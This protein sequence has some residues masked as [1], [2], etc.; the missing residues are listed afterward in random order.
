[1]ALKS[2]V[3]DTAN[4]LQLSPIQ[5]DARQNHL[6][7]QQ[8]LLDKAEWQLIEIAPLFK[9]LSYNSTKKWTRKYSTLS[10]WLLCHMKGLLPALDQPSKEWLHNPNQLEETPLVKSLKPQF[11][12]LIKNRVIRSITASQINNSISDSFM[13]QLLTRR[14]FQKRGG[15]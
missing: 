15:N 10:G 9:F 6:K 14:A 5:I 2:I 11:R 7:E 4:A 13:H 1:M 12:L 8:L 3:F